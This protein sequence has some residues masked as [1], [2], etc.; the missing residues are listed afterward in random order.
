MDQVRF[1]FLMQSF[2]KMENL[3]SGFQFQFFKLFQIKRD[4]FTVIA[5]YC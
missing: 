3:V 5:I 4:R 2:Y 1:V